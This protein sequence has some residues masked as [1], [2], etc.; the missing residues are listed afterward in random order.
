MSI[1]IGELEKG[2]YLLFHASKLSVVSTIDEE[3][4]LINGENVENFMEIPIDETVFEACGFTKFDK[5]KYRK[6]FDNKNKWLVIFRGG[7]F[8]HPW[9]L[10]VVPEINIDLIQI[11]VQLFGLHYLQNIYTLITKDELQIN[12]VIIKDR[13][14]K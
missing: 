11:P 1:K 13:Y 3:N 5:D 2:N 8:V 7:N 4:T 6:Y 10:K 9:L 14:E 12:E